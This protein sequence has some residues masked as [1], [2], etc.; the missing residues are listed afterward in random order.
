MATDWAELT[1]KPN[2]SEHE[3]MLVAAIILL[4][5]QDSF[6]SWTFERIYD[7]L[8]EIMPE[9]PPI[10]LHDYKGT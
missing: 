10:L 5:V 3:R 4:S 2:K 1:R 6:A 8:V 7:R 9:V